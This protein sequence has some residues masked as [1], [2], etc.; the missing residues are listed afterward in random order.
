MTFKE[1]LKMK[2]ASFPSG[3]NPRPFKG[4]GSWQGAAQKELKSVG[5]VKIKEKQKKS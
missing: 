3:P 4:E 1:W 2:E 5:P